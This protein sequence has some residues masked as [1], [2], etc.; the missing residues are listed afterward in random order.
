MN[1][2]NIRNTVLWKNMDTASQENLEKNW[3]IFTNAKKQN[4]Y[5]VFQNSEL[6]FTKN[7]E[8]Q[9]TITIDKLSLIKKLYTTH[10]QE[11]YDTF[12]K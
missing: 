8:C 6:Q 5:T 3:N 7:R 12:Q 1:I 11:I 4:I 2:S 9:N 10:M